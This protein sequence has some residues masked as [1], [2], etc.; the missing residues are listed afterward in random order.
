MNRLFKHLFSPRPPPAS[1]RPTFC[2]GRERP[3]CEVIYEREALRTH[4]LRVRKSE[5]ES[6]SGATEESSNPAVVPS[7]IPCAGVR[8]VGGVREGS[9]GRFPNRV[10][11][12]EAGRQNAKLRVRVLT[13]SGR[14]LHWCNSTDF[15]GVAPHAPRGLG[16]VKTPAVWL[17]R[18]AR[19]W[20]SRFRLLAR[21]QKGG[22][23]R[24][25]DLF[26]K[27]R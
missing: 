2:R 1:F 27:V 22:E 12:R 17:A 19:L 16:E 13:L 25:V 14:V 4:R 11:R 18:P 24:R 9:R 5:E 10:Q 20:A 15:C 6:Q 7:C 26:R 3:S 21:L 23:R 8:E